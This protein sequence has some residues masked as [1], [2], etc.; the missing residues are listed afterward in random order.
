V[1]AIA[2]RLTKKQ[3]QAVEMFGD[4][5]RHTM[6][7]GGSRSGK[8]FF[9][10]RAIVVRA[11]RSTGS[12]HVIWRQRSN[13]C[14]ASVWLDTFKKVMRICF[15]NVETTPHSQDGYEE[16][17]NGAQIWFAGLDDKER[18]EKILG[19][20][21]ATVYLNECSQIAYGSALM[22]LTRLAQKA[23]GIQNR[24]YCDLNPTST[25]HWTYKLFIEHKDPISGQ[26]LDPSEYAWM[27]M[28]PDDN[29]ENID[30][31]YLKALNALPER[32]RKR[33][34]EGAYVAELDG[35]LWTIER[36]EKTRIDVTDLP[37]SLHRVTVS[38]DPSG[39][40]GKEDQRSD[41][42]GLNVAAKKDEHFFVLNDASGRF[43]P[44]E[45]GAIACRLR[46]DHHADK[47]IGEKNFGGDMVRAVIQAAE[48]NAPFKTVT[49]TRGK[50]VRAEPVAALWEQGNA[51]LVGTFPK[52]EEQ[53]LAFSTSGYMGELS[54]DRADAMIW[55][56]HEL[57]FPSETDDGL[58]AFYEKW[59]DGMAQAQ[60]EGHEF[61]LSEVKF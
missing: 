45:W 29:T 52:L 55:N 39:S 5:Q 48:R 16:F 24:F 38:V 14:R 35:A 44:E 31:M 56:G 30:P 21:F 15:P 37:L 41:E 6:L 17:P 54:P 50:V 19:M 53:M 57:M 13:A 10:V 61:N 11:L 7:V 49:A 34:R 42:I 36:I 12:R 22:A 25:A 23:P 4:A 28:N 32:L 33:F 58:L 2:F 20:E 43:S 9:I 27:R 1:A 60:R 8:T 26:P 40:K 46:R 3:R 47:I 59:H 18:V 51:H